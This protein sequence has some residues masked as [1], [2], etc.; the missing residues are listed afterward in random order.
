MLKIMTLGVLGVFVLVVCSLGLSYN[1][2]L[3]DAHSYEV[4]IDAQYTDNQ[5]V[6]DNGFKKVKEM[7]QVPQLQEQAL[8]KLFKASIEA[9]NYGGEL[10]KFVKEQNPN[11]DQT[12]FIK[13]QQAIE[14]YRNGF[15][16][17]Q[18]E[19]IAKKQS[20]T[21]FLT[22]TTSGRF[23]NSLAGMFGSKFPRIDMTKFS[24]VTSDRTEN[25]FKTKKDEP[26]DLLTK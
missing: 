11:L 22:A 20:Y 6:Y 23:N 8:E 15:Q 18:T 14:E 21:T 2:F 25:V 4:T 19:L 9:R 13:I 3:N 7:A 26:L 5:N 16:R 10:I 17:A 24:I 1:G 12:T